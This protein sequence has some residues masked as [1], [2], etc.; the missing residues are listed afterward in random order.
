M[1]RSSPGERWAH[2]LVCVC[3]IFFCILRSVLLLLIWANTYSEND[4]PVLLL[5]PSWESGWGCIHWLWLGLHLFPCPSAA[6]LPA[7]AGALLAFPGTPRP[8]AR[9]PRTGLGGAHWKPSSQWAESW[10]SR[11]GRGVTVW[12]VANAPD[13]SA[14]QHHGPHLPEGRGYWGSTG[15]QWQERGG[16]EL[17]QGWKRKEGFCCDLLPRNTNFYL[18]AALSKSGESHCCVMFFVWHQPICV[19]SGSVGAYPPTPSG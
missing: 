15:S 9:G 2:V 16:R 8:K 3:V 12:A 1:S 6:T 11:G 4:T 7:Q 14:T 19:D 13:P 18:Q 17:R 10:G 5:V